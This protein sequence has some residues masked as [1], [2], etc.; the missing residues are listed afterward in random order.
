MHPIAAT[1]TRL[2]ERDHDAYVLRD[3]AVEALATSF[4]DAYDDGCA[5]EAAGALMATALVWLSTEGTGPAARTLLAMV[6]ALHPALARLDQ[7]KA[8]Q[9][10]TEAESAAKRFADF[11]G[12]DGGG[13]GVM[14]R[15]LDSGARPDGT[16]RANPL[17]RFALLGQTPPKRPPGSTP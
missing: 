2:L 17:A 14:D 4:G 16:T 5:F 11:S 6:L 9:L 13:V 8:A 7:T 1:A 10:R 15:V 3:H 12:N